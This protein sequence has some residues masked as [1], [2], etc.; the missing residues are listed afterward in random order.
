MYFLH[1]TIFICIL[2]IQAINTQ[3]PTIPTATMKQ[4]KIPGIMTC[5]HSNI[6][7]I[8]YSTNIIQL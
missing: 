6:S 2:P 3:P 4:F 1:F 5:A 7:N 8:F